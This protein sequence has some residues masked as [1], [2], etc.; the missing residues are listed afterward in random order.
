MWV[1]VAFRYVCVCVD[2]GVYVYI[3]YIDSGVCVRVDSGVCV[4]VDLGTCVCIDSGANRRIIIH[5]SIYV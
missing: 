5:A 1:L 2:S 4:C 3:V